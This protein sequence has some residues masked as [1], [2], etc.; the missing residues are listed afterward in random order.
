MKYCNEYCIGW[1]SKNYKRSDT[2]KHHT[3]KKLTFDEWF[4][5]NHKPLPIK[6]LEEARRRKYH[7]VWEAAQENKYES[8]E[9]WIP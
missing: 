8:T 5:A 3:E 7:K 9:Y 2:C 4:K 6:E 1:C